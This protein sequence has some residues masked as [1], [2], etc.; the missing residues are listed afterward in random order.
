MDDRRLAYLDAMGIQS[1]V[2]K[3]PLTPLFQRGVDADVVHVATGANLPLQN[4]AEAD[5]AG[6]NPPLQKGGKGGFPHP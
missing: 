5:V 3:S 6:S 1:W 4:E 2:R